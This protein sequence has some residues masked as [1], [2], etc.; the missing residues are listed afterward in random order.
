MS[1]SVELDM[2]LAKSAPLHWGSWMELVSR[3]NLL[4]HSKR[5]EI[6]DR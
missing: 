5:M 2:R 3:I 6:R 1:L 4:F